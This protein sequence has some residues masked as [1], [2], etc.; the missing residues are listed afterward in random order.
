MT[1]DFR[2]LTEL[3]EVRSAAFQSASAALAACEHYLRHGVP[4]GCQI[5]AVEIEPTKLAKGEDI[6]SALEKIRRRGREI[7]AS[8]HTIA[9]AP[10]PSKQAKARM[11][12]MVEQLAQRGQPDCSPLLEAGRE[13]AWPVTTVKSMVPSE[14]PQLAFAEVPDTIALFAWLHKDA[15][16]KRLDAEIDA[17]ADD[18]ASLS[19]GDRE[20]RTAEAMGDLLDVE[21][22]EA[23]LT[24][25]AMEQ[26]LPVEFRAD[27]SPLAI[28]QVRADHRSCNSR[29]GCLPL[30]LVHGR[31]DCFRGRPARPSIIDRI[32]AHVRRR[33]RHPLALVQAGDGAIVQVDERKV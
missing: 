1:D 26:N 22:Q 6:F 29:W 28:L 33:A 21:S 19:V 8:L 12:E 14:Q 18:P 10:F 17:E 4:D 3:Q 27:C 13:I 16:I 24:W 32:A 31:G 2:R 5:E 23:S 20:I 25:S 11:R 30:R 15:L 7:K 9:S